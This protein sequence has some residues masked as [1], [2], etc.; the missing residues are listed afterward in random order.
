MPAWRRYRARYA[1]YL[2]IDSISQ[3]TSGLRSRI[4]S[5]LTGL[6]VP[7]SWR[8]EVAHGGDGDVVFA[9]GRPSAESAVTEEG[10]ELDEVDEDMLRAIERHRQT[11]RQDHERRLSRE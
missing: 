9:S 2:P 5:R 3:H 10:E 4:T 11:Y 6:F 1:Q 8:R 7:W